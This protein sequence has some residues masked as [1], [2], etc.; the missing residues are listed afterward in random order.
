MI[1]RATNT[2]IWP[3]HGITAGAAAIAAVL[4]ASV[5]LVG[6]DSAS[7][8]PPRP[9]ELNEPVA[10]A[11]TATFDRSNGQATSSAPA[12]GKHAGEGTRIVELILGRPPDDDRVFFDTVLR[13]DLG[14][15][16]IPLRLT[17]PDAQKPLS[18]E[19]LAAAIRAAVGRGAAGLVVEPSDEA[20]VIDALHDAVGRGVAVILLDRSVP[21]RWQVDPTRRV[22]SV[23]RSGHSDRRGRPGGG[24]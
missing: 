7:F 5:V 10:P 23:H 21:A 11:I 1:L 8:V 12:A 19:A 22:Y 14:K 15:Y 6:C 17:R 13:R 20:G 2:L 9:P 3:V 18:P 4:A 24:P 16:Q